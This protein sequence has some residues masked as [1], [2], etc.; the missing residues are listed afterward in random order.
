[1]EKGKITLKLKFSSKV[2]SDLN[3]TSL[4]ENLEGKSFI[5]GKRFLENQEDIIKAQI[6]AWPF[7]LRQIPKDIEKIELKINVDTSN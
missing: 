4:K 6:S 3:S 5:E 7:W 2:F 1:L